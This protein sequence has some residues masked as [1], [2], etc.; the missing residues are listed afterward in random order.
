[1]FFFFHLVDFPLLKSW[2][3]T[4]R[5]HEVTPVSALPR[6]L[7]A[8]AAGEVGARIHES[9]LPCYPFLSPYLEVL[10]GIRVILWQEKQK[11]FHF[12]VVLSHSFNVLSLLSTIF[13]V[14]MLAVVL[15][16]VRQASLET[17]VQVCPKKEKKKKKGLFN[18]SEK[19]CFFLFAWVNINFESCNALDLISSFS[20]TFL[21]RNKLIDL[22]LVESY[23]LFPNSS[24]VL[25]VPMIF[26]NF[27]AVRDMCK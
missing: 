26:S 22:S 5:I 6:S 15:L 17:T 24:L 18:M 3:L 11:C 13:C 2:L 27:L 4:C 25:N 20:G 9:L 7:C 12:M 21:S 10:Y 23:L 16:W 14:T 8:F 19:S 1:L